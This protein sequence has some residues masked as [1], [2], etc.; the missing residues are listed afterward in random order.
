M[1]RIRRRSGKAVVV[2][3]LSALGVLGLSPL[4]TS[5]S[6][7]I[8]SVMHV[9]AM[10]IA[11]VV[12]VRGARRGDLPM[13]RT[14]FWL[15]GSLTATI[16]GGLAGFGYVLVQGSV[17]VPSLGDLTLLWVPMAVIGF[18]CVP[19]GQGRSAGTIRL[20][21][22]GAVAASALFFTSWLLVIE[23]VWRIGRGSLTGRTVEVLYPVC[24]IF[25][26]AVALAVLP[27][28]RSDVR[29]LLNFVTAGLLLI[30]LSDSA[31]A[32]LFA[33]RGV[34]EFGWPDATVQAGL[35]LLIFGARSRPIGVPDRRSHAGID[36][37]LPYLPIVIAGGVGLRQIA[38]GHRLALS[39]AL[40]GAVML[41][42]LV[43][44]QFV[45]MREIS[46]AADQ[47]RYDASHDSLTGLANRTAFF[48]RLGEH[49]R[50]PGSGTAA[51]LLFDLDGFKE[52]NDT[53]GHDVGDDIL[54]SFAT[55]LR[56]RAPY[57]MAARLGGDEF[58]VLVTGDHAELLAVT[59]GNT[60]AEGHR[61]ATRGH[62]SLHVT[63]SIGIALSRPE[64]SSESLLRRADLAMYT[65]KR[66]PVCRLACFS[67][68]MADSAN[69]RHL[70][71][72]DLERAVEAGELALAYQPLYGLAD[73]SVIGAEAMLRWTHRDLGPVLPH[74]L[75]Q[76]AEDI[77]YMEKLVAWTLDQAVWQMACWSRC[78]GSPQSVLVS[79]PGSQFSAALPNVLGVVLQTHGVDAY[80][81]ILEVTASELPGIANSRGLQRLHDLGA[82]IAV[83]DVGNGYSSFA[84]LARSP[85]DMLR[86]SRKDILSLEGV[87]RQRVLD[88]LLGLAAALGLTAVTTG[89]DVAA[90]EALPVPRT[91]RDPLPVD[92]TGHR[93]LPQVEE[94][95]RLVAERDA[96]IGQRDG[97]VAR[98]RRVG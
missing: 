15:A 14:R 72:A 36:R 62:G 82:R 17:P 68:D 76:I 28:A 25:V 97:P 35:V 69:R 32:V 5:T 98:H 21:A 41:A 78:A 37:H 54:L 1:S 75:L 44:R 90:P 2:A 49:L 71:G 87:T 43:W 83:D 47:H 79:L 12:L 66:S 18:W 20:V 4:P 91:S 61:L 96:G 55:D 63:C 93:P 73:R 9:A 56:H 58:A 48:A 34:A 8:A 38:L 92:I 94:A 16:V 50:T 7:A 59:F 45:Y 89:I 33:R 22:D 67:D 3:L 80:R 30:A 6:T 85:I 11:L 27:R 40:P 19:T 74:E 95:V 70:L 29:E 60:L 31:S 39:E 88:A 84:L 77:G 46:L 65:A 26:A 13:R 51:V 57:A 53:H 24:D 10:A 86:I 23:P 64:D 42:A 52:V 81:V